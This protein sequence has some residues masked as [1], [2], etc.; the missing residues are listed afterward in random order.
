MRLLRPASVE[1][2]LAQLQRDPEGTLVYGGGLEIGFGLRR[3]TIAGSALLDIK[4][5]PDVSGITATAEEIRVGPATRH[6]VISTDDTIRT[7][8]PSLGRA[9]GNVGS[10]RIRMQGTLGGNFGHGHQ[11][12]DPGTAAV[13]LGG[14]IDLVGPSGAR[15]VPAAQFWHGP[16]AV[17]RRPDELITAIR[18]SPLGPGWSVV[19]DRV[20]QLHRP[21]NAVVSLAARLEDGVLRDVRVGAGGVPGHPTRLVGVEDVVRG[22]RLAR[23]R[24]VWGDVE[25]ALAGEVTSEADLLGSAEFKLTLLSG[26][27]RRAFG[28]LAAAAKQE[29]EVRR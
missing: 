6:H 2:A 5:V 3:G 7:Y 8:L 22:E 11:H 16:Y 17:E 20:E 23:L 21:P 4:R 18:F 13:M 25:R 1:E 15:T 14:Q 27:I 10:T 29:T 26:L 12:T 19:H 9:C 28:R 24:P